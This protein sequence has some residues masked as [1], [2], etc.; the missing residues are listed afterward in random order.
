VRLAILS[1]NRDNVKV[2]L[3]PCKNGGII[4]MDY[5]PSDPSPEVRPSPEARPSPEKEPLSEMRPSAHAQLLPLYMTLAFLG[6]LAIGLVGGFLARPLIIP[7]RVQVVEV[8]AT[9]ELSTGQTAAVAQADEAAE[10]DS[11]DESN[12]AT[13]A[14][15]A[16]AEATPTIM[17]FLLADAKHSLG[18]DDAPVTIIEFS[19]FK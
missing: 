16:E 17:D 19:D 7:D 6:V 5:T 13:Q 4:Y 10:S 11:S 3:N 14:T 2:T 12:G 9:A 8:A 1:E 15:S 18:P